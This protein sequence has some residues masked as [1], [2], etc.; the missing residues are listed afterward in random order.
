MFTP[1]FKDSG[2]VGLKLLIMFS[3]HRTFR[4]DEAPADI[5]VFV[6]LDATTGSEMV[7]TNDAVVGEDNAACRHA[8]VRSM[9]GYRTAHASYQT[10]CG[11]S[12]DNKCAVSA[13]KGAE[14]DIGDC[15]K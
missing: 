10:T 13:R 2:R 8:E 11:R 1:G 9:I 12:R 15:S 7:G 4:A 5:D 3:E 14:S 6:V